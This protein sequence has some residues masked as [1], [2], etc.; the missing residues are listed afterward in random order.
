M[1]GYPAIL[2]YSVRTVARNPPTGTAEQTDEFQWILIIIKKY[3][4]GRG[5]F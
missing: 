4:R 1:E 2:C 3:F 5:R